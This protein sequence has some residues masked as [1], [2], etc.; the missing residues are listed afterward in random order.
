M[1]SLLQF[2]ALA[3]AR[4]DGLRAE[5][6]ALFRNGATVTQTDLTIPDR[7][8]SGTDECSRQVPVTADLSEKRVAATCVADAGCASTLEQ[9]HHGR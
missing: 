8:R 4:G 2:H 7:S 9:E 5:L 6:V 1:T 3:A